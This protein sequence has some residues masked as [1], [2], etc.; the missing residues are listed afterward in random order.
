MKKK[1]LAVL[2][3]LVMILSVFPV[4]A[5]AEA[6]P[7]I[8]LYV[9]PDKTEAKIGDVVTY[10]I[11]MWWKNPILCF[12]YDVVFPE[13]LEY[14]KGSGKAVDGTAVLL[15]LDGYAF[16][17]SQESL[18]GGLRTNGYKAEAFAMPSGYDE[19]ALTVLKA[20][21]TD[22]AVGKDLSVELQFEDT[23]LSGADEIISNVSVVN[24]VKVTAEDAVHSH[25]E[26]I[27]EAVE[28]D[29]INTGLTEGSHCSECGEI[30]ISQDVIP[31]NGHTEVTETVDGKVVV[32]CSVC[33]KVLSETSLPEI[34]DDTWVALYITPD[35]TNVKAGDEINYTVSMWWRE[36]IICFEY[37]VVLPAGLEFVTG[38]G[39]IVNAT[40]SLLGGLEG[41]YWT[42][43]CFD[44]GY[45]TN[46][47]HSLPFAMPEGYDMV[48]MTTFKVK[49]TESVSEGDNLEIDA[50]HFAMADSNFEVIEAVEVL[51]TVTVTVAHT[52]KAENLVFHA[53]TEADCVNDG[54][55]DSYVC[56]CGK[57]YLDENAANEV[58]EEELVISA[59][60]HTEVTDEGVEA[61]CTNTGLSEGKHCSVC[62]EV[63]VAQEE[64][65]ALGHT[66]KT[67][68]IPA[69]C[70]SD[71]K[72]TT[73]CT[74]CGETLSEETIPASGHT[75]VIDEAVEPDCENDGL[76]EG[77]RCSV[78]GE[79]LVAQEV[80]PA[81][82]HSYETEVTAP[83]C[84]EKGYT[85]Y[86][87]TV[88]GDNFVSD[89]VDA[90]GHTEKTTIIDA[91]CTEDGKTTTVCTVCGET[92]S[93]ETI[94][95]PG[96]TEVVD[97]AVAPDCINT[98]LTE[99]KHCEVCGE[100][101]V[102][103]EEIPALGHTEVIDEAVTP[104]CT[105]EGLTEGKHCSVCGEVL[106]AQEE[107]PA[108][109]H[110]EVIDE[111]VEPDC[112]N[113][114]LTEGKRC[115][116][117]G[118]IL[119]AQEVVPAL[120][121]SYETEVTAPDCTEK[122]YTTYTCTV[123]G[124][125]FVSDYVDALGHTEKTTIID[126]TCTEDGK[127]TTVC[128][129]CG[130]TVSEETIPAPGHTE[131]VDEAV[132]PDCINTG[133]T[134][135]KHCEVCG[136]ILVAQEEIPALGHTEVID[137]A[138]TPDCTNEGLTEGKH[139]EV[140]GEVLVAQEEVPALGHTEVVDEAVA[141]D[142]VNTGLTEGRHCSVCGET[143]VAQEVVPALGH[144]YDSGYTPPTCTEPG[145]IT[146]SCTVCGE[147]FSE[148]EIPATGHT[149]V[150]DEAV[151][152]DCTNEGLT[153]GKHCEVCGEVLVAQET[154]PAL[155]H[156]EVIDEAVTPDCTNEGLTEGKHCEVCGEVLVAQETVP[157]LGHTEVIDEAVT[158]DCTNEGLTEG[159]HCEVCGEILVA[160][161]TVPALG[162]TEVIDEAVAPDCTNEGLTEGK[163]CEVC[164]EVLVAQETVPAL[165]HTESEAVTE[166]NVSPDCVNDGSYDTVVYCTVC[167]SELSRE[168]I[169]VPA[170]G[171]TEV[172][173]EAVEPD[174]VNTGLTEGKHCE[175]CGEV[176]VAQEEVPALGH[177]EVIDEA[178]TPDCTN[179]GLTEG[180]HCEVCGEILTAQETVPA[181][182]HTPADA[183]EENS[184]RP[185]P[186]QDGSYD[187]VTYCSVCG[188]ELERKT[189]VIPAT[190][191]TPGEW[192]EENRKEAT[193]TENGSYDRV[194]YCVD[195]GCDGVELSRETFVIYATGHVK[196][197]WTETKAP[198]CTAMGEET[199]FCT[200]CGEVLETRETEKLSH[201]YGE[202]I[203][204]TEADCTH[205]GSQYRECADCD[206]KETGLIPALGHTEGTWK[207]TKAAT[208][209]GAGEETLFC[210][211]CGGIVDTRETEK[212]PHSYGEWISLTEADCIHDG[213]QYRECADCDAKETDVI[214]ALGHSYEAVA[215]APTM[216]SEGYTTYTCSVCG[217][218]YVDDI[219]PPLTAV[220]T[221]TVTSFRSDTDEITIELIADGETDPAYTI[222]VTGNS[223][224][225]SLD[226][227]TAGEYI[228]R[229][230]KKDHVTR[231]YA[232]T[233][234]SQESVVDLKI[235]LVGDVDGN[236]KVNT[237]DAS[238]ANAHARG[239]QYLGDYESS[240]GDV[241]FDTRLNTPDV[242]RINAHAR[243]VEFLW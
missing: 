48:D 17:D 19:V 150:I 76:T 12:E 206:A 113:D 144:T 225:Y 203:P 28:A 102:A 222:V 231:E 35:K 31:A 190:G 58:S 72:T 175:V 16:T 15:G 228:L 118:E 60:G 91:T 7:E 54:I 210:T 132:A 214:P 24:R 11:S 135:G 168:T 208:C 103:Q 107:V 104:D 86:T 124:D 74:V 164:S 119:V 148:Q 156:T 191:H 204:L 111:A 10:T 6:E 79:I 39:S 52:C 49:V 158:P 216:T 18:N 180:K 167:E 218:S 145:K 108:L 139:C 193:C 192:V 120:G 1:I 116:V 185:T 88:C 98:G 207:E 151:T 146:G 64:I 56:Q 32:S 46:G 125:N 106:V 163:H 127:T 211:V 84:T 171:H 227:V 233:V 25:T 237:I 115:S 229:V 45:R 149:E 133:L 197:E 92:V 41:Y 215:T 239:V 169:T 153:E 152:P 23:F 189:V 96:H 230:S 38:S 44:G 234:E 224:E 194:I 147:T 90:L 142:C 220:I 33:G 82:G 179:E 235:H 131:V 55:K 172:I 166:N 2:L 198:T 181:L 42:E 184:V 182:G 157:A 61:G 226:G 37:D 109:G 165:G 134:E 130:E 5:F 238:K 161:E 94:P 51:N 27:D 4:S 199:I 219:V 99:G 140:C 212:L 173:D 143:I 14:V 176:L 57:I 63:L 66:E 89:Y 69:T 22:E 155:G 202:W 243:S 128:T 178:V 93:E 196:G 232:I 83:D 141:P 9:T 121:H 114:G 138:V 241:N 8:I 188:E 70:T 85:T 105:N 205:A 223:A 221:G 75:E 209:T 177:T 97:E 47:F 240:C 26:V 183:V 77:K 137:E 200:A 174:C 201:S 117:C 50:N 36:P 213:S 29:C 30:L 236:G 59:L 68:T 100:I 154:V 187:M 13:G 78:C 53:G 73:A 20:K 87:C 43:E 34:S 186:T 95:A 112:E 71:G 129:V 110:T 62:G 195:E 3:S 101:L 40:R 136:E 65:S 170:L 80:V 217:D 242:A 160:Q 162:H 67:E 122:G 159:K 123:C 81:L 21:V 126:A